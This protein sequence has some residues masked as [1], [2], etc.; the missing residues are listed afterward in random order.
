M[1]LVLISQLI[2]RRLS[3]M[4]IKKID[5][6]YEECKKI[7]KE[8][9]VEAERAAKGT[10]EE[11]KHYMTS[12]QPIEIMQ[13]LMTGEQFQGFLWGN[14]IKYSMRLGRKGKSREDAGKCWQYAKWM[15]DH[16][17]GKMIVPGGK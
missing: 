17:D 16:M 3:M 15:V 5:D 12:K 9:L 2:V 1:D 14:V 10:T 7:A 13:E 4:Q 11:A 6:Y 8:K